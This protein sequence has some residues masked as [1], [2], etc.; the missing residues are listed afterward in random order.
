MKRLL[1][2]I[3]VALGAGGAQAALVGRDINGNAVLGSDA[4][5]VFLYDTVLNVTWLRNAN[6]NGEITWD[7]A[8]TWA[9]NLI[10]GNYGGWRLPTMTSSPNTWVSWTGGT[11]ILYNVRTK[12]GIATQYQ[13]DQTVYSEMASLWYDTLGNKAYYDISGNP[14]QA[15]WGL[16]HTGDFQNL[17]SY[18]YWSGLEY[19]PGPSSAW[20]FNMGYGLQI[21]AGKTGALYALAVRDGDVLATP[22]PATAWLMLSGIGALGAAARRKPSRAR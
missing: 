3:L 19:T 18:F 10:V 16:T 13:A 15:G 11:D 7:D 22:I 5:S 6:V 8:K 12:D 2:V 4:S 21:N 14:D 17:Q 20:S 1:L 9:A